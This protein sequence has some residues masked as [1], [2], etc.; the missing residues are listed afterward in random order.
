MVELERK[1][2]QYM[3]EYRFNH[4]L[5]VVNECKRLAKLFDT[6]SDDLVIAAYLHDVTKE[7][8]TDEQIKLCENSGVILDNCTLRSPKTLHS[9]SAPA[10]IARDFPEYAKPEIITPIRYHTTGRADMT[11]NE[12]L[13]YLADYI[14][15]T[16]RFDDCKAL[17]EYFYTNTCDIQKRLDDT[18]TLSLKYTISD[19]L[20]K[21]EYIHLETIRAYNA[22][23]KKKGD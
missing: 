20:E 2:R 14:E 12:K 21:G 6:N 8:P 9:Y 11:L 1:I 4:T 7:M 3:S 16:R 5:S 18:I 10:L 17:R 19:L 13:L 22:L 23:T 15:P